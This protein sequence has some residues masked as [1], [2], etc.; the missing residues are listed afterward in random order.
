MNNVQAYSSPWKRLGAYLIDTIILNI[1]FGIVFS[2]SSL[3]SLMRLAETMGQDGIDQEALASE[4]LSNLVGTISIFILVMFIYFTLMHSSS[5]QATI[6]K[7]ALKIK[8]VNQHGEGLSFVQAAIRFLLKMLNGFTFG[9]G[10]LIIFF[11]QG[12]RCLHDIL[13]RTYVED[14]AKEDV[15]ERV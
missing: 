8:V 6:G 9:I 7:I 2:L 12:N 3:P 15:F 1:V 14:V 4:Y 5:R 11:T 13:G 10:Y